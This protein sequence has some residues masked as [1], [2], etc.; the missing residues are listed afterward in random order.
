MALIE[1]K[2]VKIKTQAGEEKTYILS[3][4]PAIQGR[5]ILCKYPLSGLPKLGDYAVNEETM[6]KLISFVA[7]PS[8]GGDIAL[9]TRQ[10]IENH[11]PDWETLTKIEVGMIEYNCSFFANGGASIFLKGFAQKVQALIT[12]TL[13]S[14]L[15]QSSPKAEQPSTNSEQSIP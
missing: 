8:G 5:E 4:F 3:K 15:R 2:E 1:P 10:L 13:T 12:Q 6:F 11:V 14:S 7:V 9:T